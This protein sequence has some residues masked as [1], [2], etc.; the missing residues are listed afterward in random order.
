MKRRKAVF[1]GFLCSSLSFV[2]CR[3]KQPSPS[4]PQTR[5]AS[6]PINPPSAP[7]PAPQNILSDASPAAA[8]AAD[9]PSA[10][11]PASGGYELHCDDSER[12]SVKGYVANQGADTYQVDGVVVFTFINSPSPRS[13]VQV[14]A[15]AMIGPHQTMLAA[16]A[17]PAFDL[18]PGET[19]RFD[20][21]AAL[22]KLGP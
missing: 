12:T 18:A 8:P 9:A 16:E 1:L 21:V 22:K 17:H 14:T 4:A 6:P 10:A 20:P 5:Q 7:D 3:S 13:P 2:G 11:V 19:C 15:S